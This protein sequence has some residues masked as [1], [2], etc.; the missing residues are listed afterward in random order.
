MARLPSG[1]VTV[2][3]TD[4]VG[5]VG[6]WEDDPPA[7]RAALA[8]HDAI[9]AE[10]IRAYH[11]V[12]VKQQGE[13]DSVFAVF[14]LA[15]EAVAAGLAIQR[16]LHAGPWPTARP[17]RAR[18]ALHTGEARLRDDDYLGTAVNRCARLRSIGHGGQILLS[19]ATAA[20]TRD[21]L[22]EGPR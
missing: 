13:G 8:R 6:L 2:L 15:T 10:V 19:E 1:T 3:L 4:L 12:V 21:G 17:L 22:P 16:A 7:R 20:L 5:S 9:L 18:L 11:G 14:A